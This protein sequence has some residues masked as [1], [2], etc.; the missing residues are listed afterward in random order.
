[1]VGRLTQ[2]N[3]R[4]GHPDCRKDRRFKYNSGIG[5]HAPSLDNFFQ[6]SSATKNKKKNQKK[7]TCLLKR[8]CLTSFDSKRVCTGFVYDRAI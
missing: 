8:E 1:M 4:L 5:V 3:L 7:S 2:V 6:I